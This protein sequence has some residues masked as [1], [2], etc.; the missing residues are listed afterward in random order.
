MFAEHIATAGYIYLTLLSQCYNSKQERKKAAYFYCDVA[1]K[2]YSGGIKYC[3][4]VWD[5]YLI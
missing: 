5:L 2:I 3:K 4:V 1:L